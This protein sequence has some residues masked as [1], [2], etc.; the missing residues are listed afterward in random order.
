MKSE[1]PSHA[2][3]KSWY[4]YC[5]VLSPSHHVK[6]QDGQGKA[7][8]ELYAMPGSRVSQKE[9]AKLLLLRSEVHQGME[10]LR[11]LTNSILCQIEAGS[12]VE[13]G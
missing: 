3:Y 4:Y 11:E 2:I 12:I 5:A 9:L 1:Q 13:S 8:C 7:V 10:E 6:T